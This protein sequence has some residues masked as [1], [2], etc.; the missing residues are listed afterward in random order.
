MQHAIELWRSKGIRVAGLVEETHGLPDRVCSA[1]LLRDVVTG[2][3]YSIHL[4]TLPAGKT[5]HIDSD[6]AERA[7]AAILAQ[8]EACD[9]LVLSKFGKLEEA[10]GGLFPAFAS[11][12]DAGIPVLTTVSSKHLAAWDAFVPDAA[13]LPAD[14]AALQDWW[15]AVGR[16]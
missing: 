12:V 2:E 4:E 15:A 3:T 13:V 10:G 5:C 16:H 14:M 8:I 9:V 1:G 11:A 7:C 6:G